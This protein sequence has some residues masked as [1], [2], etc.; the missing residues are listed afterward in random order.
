MTV[1]AKQK[2]RPAGTPAPVKA[3]ELM[4]QLNADAG[5]L[6]IWVRTELNAPAQ[7]AWFTDTGGQTGAGQL[8]QGGRVAANCVELIRIVWT[9]QQGVSRFNATQHELHL[10]CFLVHAHPA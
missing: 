9:G 10:P 7:R 8:A 1:A 6:N 4:E 3:R 2:D 5:K